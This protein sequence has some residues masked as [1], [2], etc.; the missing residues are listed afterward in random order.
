MTSRSL[1]SQSLWKSEIAMLR[2]WLRRK[3]ASR[4]LAGAFTRPWLR[5]EGTKDS[6]VFSTR[7]FVNWKEWQC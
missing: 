2:W 1:A 6:P 4:D 7:F 5:T 3:N